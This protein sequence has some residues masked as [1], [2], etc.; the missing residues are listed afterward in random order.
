MGSPSPYSAPNPIQRLAAPQGEQPNGGGF[1]SHKGLKPH[2]DIAG[3]RPGTPIRGW[4]EVGGR[5]A[6]RGGPGHPNDLALRPDKA[7]SSGARSPPVCKSARGR[8]AGRQPY[9][10][11]GGTLWQDGNRHVPH[12]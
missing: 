9:G 8:D 3:F 2:L 10:H 4:G 6:C 5:A 12:S 7:G 11:A 1:Q